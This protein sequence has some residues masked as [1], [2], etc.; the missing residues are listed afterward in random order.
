[1]NNQIVDYLVSGGHDK[2]RLNSYSR[3][4]AYSKGMFRFASLITWVAWNWPPWE[5][6]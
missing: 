6:R 5:V 2:G 4:N 3:E 1:M